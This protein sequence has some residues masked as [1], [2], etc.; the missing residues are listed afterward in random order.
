MLDPDVQSRPA[1]LRFKL[2]RVGVTGVRKPVHIRRPGR[3]DTLTAGFEVFVDLPATMKGVHLSRNLEV[4]SEIVEESVRDPVPSLEDVCADIARRL[5]ERH[6]YATYGE[7]SSEAEYFL[8][9]TTPLGTATTE[10]YGLMARARIT[11]GS[12]LTLQKS[13]GV[14]VMGMTA[15]PCAMETIKFRRSQEGKVP[16]DGTP[17]ITHNQRTISRLLLEIPEGG[18]VEADDLIDM[19]ED[20]LSSP[21]Y[22]ILKRGD[23][24][25][26][27]EQA[28]RE[29]RFVEDVVREILARLL[30]KYPDFPD[31]VQVEVRSES[32]ESIHKH[33]AVAERVTTFG[34]LRT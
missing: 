10:R 5:L 23:E 34:E 32:E 24:A 26:V 13:I 27:V 31:A 4:V 22:E 11:R 9:R 20:S 16:E 30:K 25:E 33:N 3:S 21:S 8:P 15:C 19:V 1:E 14:E 12:P 6:E 28:H 17:V 18:E 29:P 7:V 2:T